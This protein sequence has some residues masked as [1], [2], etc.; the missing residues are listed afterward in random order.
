MYWYRVVYHCSWEPENTNHVE[1][2][3]SP[4][5]DAS[6]LQIKAALYGRRCNITHWMATDSSVDVVEYNIVEEETLCQSTK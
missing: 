5:A 3:L 1:Y 6:E 4:I 2:V